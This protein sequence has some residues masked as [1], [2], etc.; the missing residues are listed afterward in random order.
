MKLSS[1]G[2]LFIG[3]VKI[4]SFDKM[5]FNCYAP[6]HLNLGCGNKHIK[7]F[8]NIDTNADV[9]PDHVHDVSDIS[10]IHEIFPSAEITE[11][12]AYDII[13]HFDRFQVPAVL[14][15]WYDHLVPGGILR[16]RTNDLER[17]IML[18]ATQPNVFPAE[19]FIW[20]L[21]SEHEKPGMGHKWCF[22]RGTMFGYLKDA[23][24]TKIT[25]TPTEEVERGNYPHSFTECDRCNMHLT[26]VKV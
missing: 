26:A 19:K 9:L 23:G 6:F 12:V 7:G 16:I 5:D 4:V 24:F 11:I 14:K 8:Y 15:N 1:K 10:F 22:T 13:E 17:M 21:M 25:V 18:Y 20:H 3:G 2:E